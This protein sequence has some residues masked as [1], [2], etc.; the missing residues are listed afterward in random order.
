M[1]AAAKMAHSRALSAAA[2]DR[3]ISVLEDGSPCPGDLLRLSNAGKL[4][5]IKG[6]GPFGAAIL[7]GIAGHAKRPRKA[8]RQG[9]TAKPKAAASRKAK[10]NL[11]AVLARLVRREVRRVVRQEVRSTL[12]ELLKGEQ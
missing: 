5:T 6:I 1:S 10:G 3:R 4:E 8:K 9:R 2:R 7:E 11:G 12:R